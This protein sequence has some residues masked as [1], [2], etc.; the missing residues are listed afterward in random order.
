MRGC[1][2]FIMLFAIAQVCAAA[3]VKVQVLDRNGRP[4]SG[5]VVSLDAPN[6]D[7]SAAPSEPAMDQ[8]DQRFVPFTLAVRTGTAVRFPNSDSVAHQVYSFSSP[9][10]FELGLYRGRPHAPVTFDK[11]GVVVL[12]CNIHD[13]MIGYVYVTDATYFGKTDTQ[14]TWRAGSVA[15][16]QYQL[17][18]W[19][20]LLA[21]DEPALRQPINVSDAQPTDI[22][23]RLTR[24]VQPEPAAQTDR[25]LRDY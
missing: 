15:P 12:G 14:G 22:V 4:V 2:L 3:P 24:P 13:K 8:I 11:P 16:A 18:V 25:K 10:R 23:I 19:S 20:P 17:D 7:R 1:V 6:I 21:R 9:K 5:L